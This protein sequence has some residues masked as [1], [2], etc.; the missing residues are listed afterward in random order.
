[1][2]LQQ[3]VTCRERGVAF[4]A[5]ESA[6]GLTCVAAAILDPDDVAVAAVSVTGPVIRFRPQAH[7]EAVRAAAAGI[8]ATLARRYQPTRPVR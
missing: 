8:S 2:L 4:E 6:V 3:L 1:M 5:E 7:A